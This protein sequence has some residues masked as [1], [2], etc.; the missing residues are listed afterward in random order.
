[1][2]SV[3]R[4]EEE[5]QATPRDSSLMVTSPLAPL[6]SSSVVAMAVA[7]A[8]IVVL[9]VWVSLEEQRKK[10]KL[11]RTMPR[12]VRSSPGIVDRGDGER[13]NLANILSPSVRELE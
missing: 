2:H 13:E 12:L 7:V 3:D 4:K 10:R 6:S 5:R 1:M 9:V 11:G 8:V